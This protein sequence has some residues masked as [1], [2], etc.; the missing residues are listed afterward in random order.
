MLRKKKEEEKMEEN[1][2]SEFVA[3]E[4]EQQVQPEMPQKRYY[5]M[6]VNDGENQETL[7]IKGDN[8]LIALSKFS[9]QYSDVCGEWIGLNISIEE[10]D[11]IE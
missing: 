11:A 3:E 4:N 1:A 10:V 2:E 7:V 6:V 5:L 8:I 9:K